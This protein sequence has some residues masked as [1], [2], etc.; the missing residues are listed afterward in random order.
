V[1]KLEPLQEEAFQVT[2]ELAATQGRVKKAMQDNTK[3]SKTPIIAH[4]I[5]RILEQE[6]HAKEK[7]A[8]AKENF[9]NFVVMCQE[10][11]WKD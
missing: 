10:V 7:A 8:I 1:Q 6:E 11:Q 2:L 3:K 4:N 9:H 5:K